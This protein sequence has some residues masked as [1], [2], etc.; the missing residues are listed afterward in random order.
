MT[1]ALTKLHVEI[2]KADLKEAATIEKINSQLKE[3]LASPIEDTYI[4]S[5]HFLSLR[6]KE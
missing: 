5:G 6:S 1:P 3:K 4:R 2:V